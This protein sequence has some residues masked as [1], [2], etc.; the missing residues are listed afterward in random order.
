MGSSTQAVRPG[1]VEI[2][3]ILRAEEIRG[4]TQRFEEPHP[5]EDLTAEVPRE[6][7]WGEL[8][9]LLVQVGLVRP[10]DAETAIGRVHRLIRNRREIGEKGSPEP[11]QMRGEGARRRYLGWH[12]GI[13]GLTLLTGEGVRHETPGGVGHARHDHP[14]VEPTGERDAD[15]RAR[16]EIAREDALEYRLERYLESIGR[17]GRLRFPG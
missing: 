6:P 3:T 7:H 8:A 14:R 16:L 2:L 12:A 10:A 17:E 5:P 15:G 4:Q 9:R 13:N 1:G 11:E